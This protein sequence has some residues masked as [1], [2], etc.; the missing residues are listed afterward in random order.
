MNLILQFCFFDQT[1]CHWPANG[2]IVLCLVLKLVAALLVV[3]LLKK[4]VGVGGFVIGLSQIH[5]FF[6][7]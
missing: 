1:G 5:S 7:S 6:S 3:T 4:Y 2:R